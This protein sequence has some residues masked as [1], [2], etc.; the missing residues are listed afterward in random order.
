MKKKINNFI[1]HAY[2]ELKN[3]SNA[4][5]YME[6]KNGLY[7]VAGCDIENVISIKLA[8]NC[9]DLQCD[10]DIDWECVDD[11]ECSIN[12][13]TDLNNVINYFSNIWGRY[14]A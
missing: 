12:N 5:Y 4:C 9:D 2:K 10:Y 14:N 7:L 6:I 8:I 13:K 11:H 3:G 1:R